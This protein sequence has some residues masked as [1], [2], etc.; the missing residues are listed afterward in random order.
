MVPLID[1]ITYL[2]EFSD[3]PKILWFIRLLNGEKNLDLFDTTNNTDQYYSQMISAL[4]KNNKN[5]FE[6]GYN[7]FSKRKPSSETIWIN[8]NFLIFILMLGIIR[9]NIDKTWIENVLTLRDNKN[10]DFQKI[11]QTFK[12]LLSGNINSMDNVFEIV[13]SHLD[14]LNQPQLSKELLDSAYLHLSNQSDLLEKHNDFLVVMSLRA[15]DVIIT[16]KDTPDAIEI[17]SL[18]NFRQIFI[19]RINLISVLIYGAILICIVVIIFKYYQES[20][21]FKDFV[22][23]LGAV[24]SILG[25]AIL[26]AIKYIRKG[27][28][29]MILSFFGYSKYFKN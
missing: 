24:F 13:I 19:K 18:K 16:T 14:F 26:A 17:T 10:A 22:N 1:K 8:D 29:L 6:E 11:N 28:K 4:S 15:F 12:N 23:D 21:D 3:K 27:V 20:K 9:Y 25:I 5:D 2:K 7:E